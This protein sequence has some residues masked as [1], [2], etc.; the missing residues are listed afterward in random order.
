MGEVS[1]QDFPKT[2]ISWSAAEIFADQDN[3]LWQMMK[4]DIGEESVGYRIAKD[5]PHEY[6]AL[7]TWKNESDLTFN[8]MQ[9]WIAHL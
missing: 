3:T 6:T 4:E 8:A 5:M 2:F 9:D 1:F 7:P